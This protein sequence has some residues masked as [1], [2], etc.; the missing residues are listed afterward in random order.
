MDITGETYKV[1]YDEAENSV[2]MEGI[3][4]LGEPAAYAPIEELLD[5][6]LASHPA[7]M[8]LDVRSLSFLDSPGI[9][10]LYKFATATQKG[11]ARLAVR[12][13]KSIPWQVESLPNLKKF[14]MNF[15]LSW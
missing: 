6:A 2:Y 13:S 15:E 9:N 8:T 3:L 11:S 1:R 12:G 14:N 7:T 10:L 5:R 4:R